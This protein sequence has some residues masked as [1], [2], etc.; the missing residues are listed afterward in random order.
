MITRDDQQ[1]QRVVSQ[2]TQQYQQ[3]QQ[4]PPT[5]LFQSPTEAAQSAIPSPC[6]PN[7]PPR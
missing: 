7:T 4:H 2:V 1:I 5:L 3:L 6:T